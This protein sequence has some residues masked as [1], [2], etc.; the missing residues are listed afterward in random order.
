M[1]DTIENLLRRAFQARKE[2]RLEEAKHDLVL[3]VEFCRNNNAR[4]ELASALT[5]LGQVER[6]L[7]CSDAAR[8][9]YEEAVA[10]YRSESNEMRLAHALRHL[11]DIHQEAG[12][13]RLADTCYREA[14]VLYRADERTHP[15]DLANAIRGLAILK[16]NIGDTEYAKTLWHEAKNLYQ[17]AEVQEGVAESTRRLARL[18]AFAGSENVR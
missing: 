13:R 10:I 15:L 6:D 2:N 17:A 7:R 12:R 5:R 11:G 8:E 4:S 9:H 14:L 3:A 18:A 16:D 1:S